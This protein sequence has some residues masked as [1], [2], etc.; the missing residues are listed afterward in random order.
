MTC[1]GEVWIRG[2]PHI[3]LEWNDKLGWARVRKSGSNEAADFLVRI[4]DVHWM[5]DDE[6]FQ[7][8]REKS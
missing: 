3:V 4:T 8:D 2:Q 1:F 7:E 6:N 5:R